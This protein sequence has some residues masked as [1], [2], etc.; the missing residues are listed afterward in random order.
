[1]LIP[2]AKG[3][4]RSPK[5]K[6]AGERLQALLDDAML[7]QAEAADLIGVD[8]RTMRRYVA[9][10]SGYPYCVWFALQVLRE[11][12]DQIKPSPSA[13]RKLKRDQLD[14]DLVKWRTEQQKWPNASKGYARAAEHIRAILDELIRRDEKRATAAQ[15]VS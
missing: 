12:R 14:A 5:K 6:E 10:R 4:K 2:N 13:L 11:H 8:H 15:H 9:G 1:M 7:S 3:W